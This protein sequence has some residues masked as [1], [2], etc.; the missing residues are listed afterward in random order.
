MY[1][2]SHAVYSDD[3]DNPSESRFATLQYSIKTQVGRTV[4]WLQDRNRSSKSEERDR[5]NK[6]QVHVRPCRSDNKLCVTTHHSCTNTPV[7]QL[8]CKNEVDAV[9]VC[10]VDEVDEDGV[11]DDLYM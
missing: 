1:L 4:S 11:Y 8:P 5:S 7:S 3:C 2:V 9:D 6:L 10:D